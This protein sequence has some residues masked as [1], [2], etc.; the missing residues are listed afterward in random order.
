MLEEHLLPWAKMPSAF[1]FLRYLGVPQQAAYVLQ[2]LVALGASATVGYVWWRCGA[3]RLAGAT[4]VSATLLLQPYVFDYEMALLAVPLAILAS[5]MIS[6][7]SQTWERIV[8]LFG[9]GMPLIIWPFAALAHFQ[10]GFP[11]IVLV[12]FLSARRAIGVVLPGGCTGIPAPAPI[13]PN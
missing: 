13:A 12:L 5:D 10:I 8:L 1:I 2:A 4:L 6:R 7:G 9:Y 11:A 3:T